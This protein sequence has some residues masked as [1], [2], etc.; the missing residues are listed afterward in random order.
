MR[1][2]EDGVRDSKTQTER[3]LV[4]AIR[5]AEAIG[6]K[7][8]AALRGLLASGFVHRTPG[9]GAVDTR[10]FLEAVSAI[11]GEILELRLEGLAVD[12]SDAGA[13]VTGIQR[14]K[15]RLDGKDIDDA[16]PFVDWFVEVDGEWRLRAAV[17]LPASAGSA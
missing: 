16:R 1:S 12:V 6:R 9:A 2:G 3:V 8:V 7:D 14:A 11:P 15:V 4:S 17:E 13:L 10:A 5:I